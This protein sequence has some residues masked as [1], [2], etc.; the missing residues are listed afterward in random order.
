MP[1]MDTS[2]SHPWAS[3]SGIRYSSLRVLLPPK[4]KPLLQSSRLA[5]RST[6]PPRCALRRFKGWIG[7]GPNVSRQRGKRFRFMAVALRIEGDVPAS[8][9]ATTSMVEKKR[10]YR[11]A[12]SVPNTHYQ[13][14]IQINALFVLLEICN[15]HNKSSR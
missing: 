3:A 7:V 2:V 14:T 6:L 1:P 9:L 10:T 5:Y 11:V 8:V 4:A 15:E 12:K 13:Q